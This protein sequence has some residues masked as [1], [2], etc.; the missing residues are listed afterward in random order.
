MSFDD[1]V[2]QAADIVINA[3]SLISITQVNV[4]AHY[5]NTGKDKEVFTQNDV[6]LNKYIR[7]EIQS[8]FPDDII[9]GEEDSLHAKVNPSGRTWLI[10]PIDGTRSFMKHYPH[11][12]VMLSVLSCG[13]PSFSIVHNIF[14]NETYCLNS[15]DSIYKLSYG[16]FIRLSPP[17]K[18]TK[19]LIWNLF[20]DER[21][22]ECLLRDI[23]FAGVVE[24]ESTGLRALDLFLGRGCAFLSLPFSAKI[25][26]TVPA[27]IVMSIVGGS[28]TDL[29]GSN[30]S[31]LGGG[32]AHSKGALASV[33]IDHIE[34][35]SSVNR[36]V[37]Q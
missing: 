17:E 5:K 24:Q 4:E 1:I 32:I 22:K 14:N 21:L 15:K 25:W 10:D 30:I 2:Y 8:Y 23:D 12:S 19:A 6:M 37:Q 18:V 9:V 33:G 28:Y 11:C 13:E 26:D 27:H 36:Y 16:S 7:K 20:S 35:L 34:F 29:Q 3:A 31:Y